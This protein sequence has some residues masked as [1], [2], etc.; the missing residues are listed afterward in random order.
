M[1]KIWMKL[2]AFILILL[3]L[4]SLADKQDVDNRQGIDRDVIWSIIPYAPIHIL[5]GSFKGQGIADTYLKKAQKSLHHYHHINQI[6]TPARAWHQ[7]AAGKSTVCHPSALK[8]AEREQ[9]AYFSDPGL[10]TPVIRALMRRDIW[11]KYFQGRKTLNLREYLSMNRGPLGIVSHRSY[12]EVVDQVLLQ[13]MRGGKN[14]VQASGRYGSRQLYEMLTNSRIELMLE[15]PWV[16]SYFKKTLGIIKA[17]VVN[18]Q[19]SEFPRFSPAYVACTRNE[20]GLEII[21]GIN[22]FLKQEIPTVNNRRRMTDWL[23]DE[24]AAVFEQDYFEFFKIAH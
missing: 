11:E 18:L 7:I 16:S 2:T 17:E 5:E 8:T 13:A 10:I 21:K 14:I 22:Q 9:Y 20:K 23:D 1:A 24:E 19:I 6:M 12:G 3:P 4:L 15:Y